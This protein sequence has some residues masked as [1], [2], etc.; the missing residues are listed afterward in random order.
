MFEGE[1][2]RWLPKTRSMPDNSSK[3]E[4]IA[5][6]NAET[7][8]KPLASESVGYSRNVLTKDSMGKYR[9]SNFERYIQAASGGI[10]KKNNPYECPL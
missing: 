4:P 2:V 1:A 5:E 8:T 3:K 10:P 9:S 7:I 6:Q